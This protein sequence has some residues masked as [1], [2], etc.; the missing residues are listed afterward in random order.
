MEIV[1]IKPTRME[2]CEKCVDNI[3]EEK[4]V[5]INLSDLDSVVARRIML[6]ISGAV[7]MQEG[8]IVNP[9]DKVYCTIPEGIEHST[10]SMTDEEPEIKP[11]Y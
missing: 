7:F 11:S 4:I 8:L 1:F 3:K 6:Y 10:I 5:H 9:A 2:D